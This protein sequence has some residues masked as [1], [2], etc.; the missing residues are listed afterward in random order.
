MNANAFI[1]LFCLSLP[2]ILSIDAVAL[3]LLPPLPGG[4]PPALQA[5][6]EARPSEK[7]PGTTPNGAQSKGAPEGRQFAEKEK[8][9]APCDPPS[10]CQ[11]TPEPKPPEKQ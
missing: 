10:K 8:K 9:R 3:D 2:N 7:T 5:V 1:A 11:G 4:G 6:P